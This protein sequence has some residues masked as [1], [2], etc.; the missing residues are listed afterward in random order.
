LLYNIIYFR[1][2]SDMY[3]T[4][5]DVAVASLSAAVLYAVEQTVSSFLSGSLMP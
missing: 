3:E 2:W 1:D 5:V 4:S